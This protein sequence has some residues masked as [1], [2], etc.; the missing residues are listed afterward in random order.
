M[1]RPT[2]LRSS[3]LRTLGQSTHF[4]PNSTRQLSEFHVYA[5]PVCALGLG[6]FSCTRI[7]HPWSFALKIKSRH[8][9][10]EY[11]E[12]GNG[13][14][15]QLIAG[16]MSSPVCVTEET[17]E[18]FRS[19]TFRSRFERTR[20]NTE[21]R[22]RALLPV[23]SETV[24]LESWFRPPG[25]SANDAGP[26]IPIRRR[27]NAEVGK[28][29]PNQRRSIVDRTNASGYRSCWLRSATRPRAVSRSL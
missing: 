11:K 18:K 5:T 22:T 21:H 8:D 2:S 3:S 9:R 19:P 20:A 29:A 25:I 4:S 6:A 12:I 27:R 15:I 17:W 16:R 26:V 14:R 28:T 7:Q 23:R 24:C 10:K 1:A 13:F